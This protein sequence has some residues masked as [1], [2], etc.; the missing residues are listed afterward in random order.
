MSSMAASHLRV[1]VAAIGL[2]LLA[3]ACSGGDDSGLPTLEEAAETSTTTTPADTTTTTTPPATTTTLSD[4]QQAE[5]EV[6]RVVLAWHTFDIDTSVDSNTEEYLDL[7]TGLQRQR[8][9]EWYEDLAEAGAIRRSARPAPIEILSTSVDVDGGQ[10]RIEV[11]I[12]SANEFVDAETL[13]ILE[14]SDPDVTHLGE[15]ELQVVNG[16]WKISN[17]L[18]TALTDDPVECEVGQ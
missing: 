15:Y 2:V 17:A 13:E 5:A 11:C 12:G 10:G 8:V 9:V 3:T 18:T 1:L 4:L 6:E 7:L 14:V 16:E